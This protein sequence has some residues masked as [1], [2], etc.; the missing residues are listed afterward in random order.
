MFSRAAVLAVA[1]AIPLLLAVLSGR[2]DEPATA[3]EQCEDMDSP[4]LRIRCLED[5]IRQLSSGASPAP[6]STANVRAS[7]GG[8]AEF[9]ESAPQP[10]IQQPPAGPPGIE[11]TAVKGEAEAAGSLP[12][13]RMSEPAGQAETSVLDEMGSEQ[14]PTAE[15]A[16]SE[17]ADV[18]VS[19]QVVAFDFVGRDKLRMRLQNGQVWRQIDADRGNFSTMLRHKEVFQVELWQTGLGGYRMRI[20]P[21]NKTVRVQRVK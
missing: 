6:G 5:A 20:L 9:A 8:T 1:S 10:Q 15:K 17:D 12:A 14:L 13:Q 4:E 19:A 3:I 7:V 2:T 21:T 16:E 18:R 11:D